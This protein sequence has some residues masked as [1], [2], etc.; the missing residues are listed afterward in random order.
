MMDE[1]GQ[2]DGTGASRLAIPASLVFGAGLYHL[3]HFRAQIHIGMLDPVALVT[4]SLLVIG[5][6][7]AGLSL[8]R[9]QGGECS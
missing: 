4:M 6:I 3:W 5:L 8:R 7:T 2:L 9:R 1:R